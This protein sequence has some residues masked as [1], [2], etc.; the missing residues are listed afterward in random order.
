ML[1]VKIP[2]FLKYRPEEDE[3]ELSKAIQKYEE[4]FGDTWATE[5]LYYSRDELQ[6][7]FEQCIEENRTFYDVIGIDMSDFD[8]DDDI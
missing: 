4:R 5:G 3:D 6:K 2:D 1:E 7:I 8:E